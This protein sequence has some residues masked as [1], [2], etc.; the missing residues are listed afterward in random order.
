MNTKM[1]WDICNNETDEDSTDFYNTIFIRYIFRC[2]VGMLVD[3][4]LKFSQYTLWQ[5]CFYHILTW[6]W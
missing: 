6:I 4:S 3:I 5:W 1:D 2:M